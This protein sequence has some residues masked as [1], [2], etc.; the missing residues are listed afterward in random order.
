MER[1]KGPLHRHPVVGIL[2]CGGSGHQ[3][4]HQTKEI[5]MVWSGLSGMFPQSQSG[6]PTEPYSAAFVRVHRPGVV[7]REVEGIVSYRE[8]RVLEL[9]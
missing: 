6:P 9:G 1:E 4:D 3:T 8:P 2:W 5:R 7:Y